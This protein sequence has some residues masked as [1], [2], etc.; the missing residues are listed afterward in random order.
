M[1]LGGQRASHNVED[2]RGMGM[3]GGGLGVGGIVIAL[4][5]Y[6]LGFD[7]GAVMQVQQQMSGPAQQGQTGAPADEAGGAQEQRRAAHALAPA[8]EAGG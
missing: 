3:V 8:Y 7:P 2:R 1:R 4:I 5:A 6:F